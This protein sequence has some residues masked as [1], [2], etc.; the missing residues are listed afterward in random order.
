MTYS[1]MEKYIHPSPAL[2]SSNAIHF[3]N[4]IGEQS[5]KSASQ[6]AGSE[7]DGDTSLTLMREIPLR[8]DEDCTRKEASPVKI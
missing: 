1:R 4:G 3:R 7:E 8:D 5:R 6:S 2:V